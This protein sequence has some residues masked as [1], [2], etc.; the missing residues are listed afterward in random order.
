MAV[1]ISDLAD[2]DLT[3]IWTE[4]VNR[5]GH[6]Q[7]EVLIA[8]FHGVFGTLDE[9][10]DVGL[11]H[12]D[13]PEGILMHPLVTYPFV[14]FYERQGEDIRVIRVLHE[15]MQRDDLCSRFRR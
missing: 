6:N 1:R 5:Y 2:A 10:P 11:S 15:K 4:S 3:R 9:F 7:A 8:R 12:P 13:L 14:V